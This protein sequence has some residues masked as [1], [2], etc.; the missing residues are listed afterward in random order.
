MFL[1]GT[2]WM[3]RGGGE[4]QMQMSVCSSEQHRCRINIGPR[5]RE[6]VDH[7]HFVATTPILFQ[8]HP[9]IYDAQSKKQKR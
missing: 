9:L 4:M 8:P 1:D 7:T 6:M 5:A 2:W 3:G